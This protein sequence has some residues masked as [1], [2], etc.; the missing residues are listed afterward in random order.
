MN[1]SSILSI[2]FIFN[3][4]LPGCDKNAAK[5]K[6]PK[7]EFIGLSKNHMVQGSLNED[8]LWLQFRFEDEDGD[9][10][11]GNADT[12]KDIT[13]KDSRTGNIQDEFKLP[14][15]IP[16]ENETQKG[17]IS[18]RVLTTCCLFKDGSPPC[19]TSLTYPQDTLSYLISIRDRAGHQS[20][21]IE[22]DKVYLLCR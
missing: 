4:L 20:N 17:T 5:D 8:T 7:I 9:L 6:I 14:D 22:S 21:T 11:F 10:G 1:R 13:L 2:L 18:I 12:R 3:L 15:L 19:A 16:S